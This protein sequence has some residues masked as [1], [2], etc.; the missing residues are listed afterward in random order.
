MKKLL[1]IVAIVAVFALSTPALA[2]F[3]TRIT[4]P[5]AR[6]HISTEDGGDLQIFKHSDGN[7]DC[8]VVVDPRYN[9]YSDI[10]CVKSNQQ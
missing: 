7:A 9:Q 10:S 3:I 5:I 2:G 6:I 4:D 8:Y 1:T